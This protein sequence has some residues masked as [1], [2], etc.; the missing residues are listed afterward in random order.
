MDD[1]KDKV[2]NREI[3]YN[4]ISKANFDLIPLFLNHDNNIKFKSYNE[5]IHTIILLYLYVGSVYNTE[6]TVIDTLS[7]PTANKTYSSYVNPITS[8]PLNI[9]NKLRGR[10][11]DSQLV[12]FIKSESDIS[13][14][15]EDDI[16]NS[17]RIASRRSNNI[18]TCVL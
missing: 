12:V 8:S 16:L 4:D 3:H 10:I 15:L 6:V 7:R 1:I 14:I 17:I 2:R 9:I 13:P 11:I 18:I 5:L